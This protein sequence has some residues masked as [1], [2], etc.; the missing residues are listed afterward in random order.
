M[1]NKSSGQA[2]AVDLEDWQTGDLTIEERAKHILMT[3]LYTDCQFL[4]GANGCEQE[5]Y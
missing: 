3:G 2:H 1:A 4:V 5:V